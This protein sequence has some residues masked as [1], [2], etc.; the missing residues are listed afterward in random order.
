MG[1]Q[2]QQRRPHPGAGLQTHFLPRAD[3]P[4]STP[5]AKAMALPSSVVRVRLM[6]MGTMAILGENRGQG[7]TLSHVLPPCGPQTSLLETEFKTISGLCGKICDPQRVNQQRAGYMTPLFIKT[8]R[9]GSEDR[10]NS[11]SI[12]SCDQVASQGSISTI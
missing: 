6:T 10:G 9:L 3:S 4:Y 2:G 5:V 1:K 8:E 12:Q 11:P 7:C